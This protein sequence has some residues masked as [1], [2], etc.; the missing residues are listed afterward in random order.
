MLLRGV[1]A[2]ADEEV[3]VRLVLVVVNDLDVNV[4]MRFL[5]FHCDDLVHAVVVFAILRGVVGC[6]DGEGDV[7]DGLLLDGDLDI[8]VALR[9]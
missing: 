3:F 1:V 6:L 8:L 4:A 9:Y 5:G 7:L 2:E